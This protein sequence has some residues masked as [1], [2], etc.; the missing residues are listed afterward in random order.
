L[1]AKACTRPEA[2][3][4][5]ARRERWT[6]EQLGAAV[7]MS[8]SQAHAILA[9]A[10]IKPHLTEC[11]GRTRSAAGVDSSEPGAWGPTCQHDS[12]VV[13]YELDEQPKLAESLDIVLLES[14]G[15]PC[16]RRTPTAS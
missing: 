10:A 13:R 5:G 1:I 7:G 16:R 12:I 11:C 2:T 3:A 9:R 8:G 4:E 14:D 15:W 6:H